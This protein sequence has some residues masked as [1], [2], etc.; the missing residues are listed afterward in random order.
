MSGDLTQLALVAIIGVDAIIVLALIVVRVMSLRANRPAGQGSMTAA[1]ADIRAETAAAE[2]I[3]F[4]DRIESHRSTGAGAIGGGGSA[5]GS[6]GLAAV[7]APAAPDPLPA[8][9]A[10]DPD[11]HRALRREAGRVARYGRSLTVMQFEV[12]YAPDQDVAPGQLAEADALLLGLVTSQVRASDHLAHPV[13]G[14][15]WLLLPE[16]DEAAALWVADRIRNQYVQRH[17]NPPRLL[18]GWA[19]TEPGGGVEST[20]RR[21]VER[22][23]EDRRRA[24]AHEEQAAAMTSAVFPTRSASV[25]HSLMTL[26]RLRKAGF[27]TDEE[28]RQ[29]RADILGRV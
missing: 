10:L 27:V 16:T 11:W 1:R 5:G 22:V 14:R 9:A 6:S 7:P 2:P 29:K 3:P 18:V 15:L 19:G 26:E 20:V 25:D 17:P 4:P 8:M 24:R 23:H 21:A 12:D 13:P 28:Y